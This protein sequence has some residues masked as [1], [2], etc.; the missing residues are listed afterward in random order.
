[1]ADTSPSLRRPR[2]WSLGIRTASA[3]SSSTTRRES[4]ANSGA[5]GDGR[6]DTAAISGDGQFVALAS[7]AANLIPEGDWNGL[8]D[9]FVSAVS[10]IFA[11]GFESGA[12]ALWG[13]ATL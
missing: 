11:D 3:T 9:I 12:T 2:T 6:S 7:L 4:I 10:Q 13:F 5:Q 8:S 1:M